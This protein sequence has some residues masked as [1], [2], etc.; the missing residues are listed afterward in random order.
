MATVGVGPGQTK[1]QGRDLAD[2]AIVIP[3]FNEEQSL[4]LVL[5][6]LPKVGRLIVVNNASTDRTAQVAAERGATVVDQP[7]R[8]YGS[9]CLA[10]LA[11]IRQLIAAGEPAPRIVAFVDADYSD[12]VDMLRAIVSPI[13]DGQAD[14]VLGSR[15]LGKREPGAMPPQSVYGNLLACFL[16][17]LLFGSRYTDL[18]P[19]RAIDYEALERLGMV[20]E[21][22]GWTVEM[23]IKATRAG[24]RVCEI[25]VPYRRRIG[26]SKISGTLSGTVKAGYKI[27]Y[28]IAKYGCQR[29]PT[30]VAT[31]TRA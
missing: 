10:G 2:V 5:A 28:T 8:G 18:G 16:M 1:V 27:L 22:F 29:R 26:E 3:A 30:A 19:F 21:N 9:A 17:R 20:D 11:K 4:P 15:L 31:E 12:H 7:Q 6:D 24:L 14:L 25:P 23:Q 13:Y